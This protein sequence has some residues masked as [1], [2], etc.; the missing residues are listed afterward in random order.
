[1]VLLFESCSRC[2]FHQSYISDRFI[3]HLLDTTRKLQHWLYISSIQMVVSESVETSTE[4]GFLYSLSH[5]E[6]SRSL[7]YLGINT[8]CL[9]SLVNSFLTFLLA[10]HISYIM[11][12]IFCYSCQFASVIKRSMKYLNIL[13]VNWMILIEVKLR[14]S[15]LFANWYDF[16]AKSKSKLFASWIY[17]IRLKIIL[18]NSYQF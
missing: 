2:K 10:A 12:S 4:N 8:L 16:I 11:E 6:S 5:F 13:Y 14:K 15:R 7:A 17:F 1:M 9:D 18:L 3:L